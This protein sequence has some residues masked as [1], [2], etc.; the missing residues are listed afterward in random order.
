[1]LCR[2]WEKQGRIYN[3][4]ICLG[5]VWLEERKL[6][7]MLRNTTEDIYSC[8]YMKYTKD[9]DLHLARSSFVNICTYV[10]REY[11]QLPLQRGTVAGGQKQ[12]GDL[13]VTVQAVVPFQ[14]YLCMSITYLNENN[15]IQIFNSLALLGRINYQRP[16]KRPLLWS[17]QAKQQ[18]RQ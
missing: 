8:K 18:Q 2:V 15:V 5:T 13:L 14:F 12:E 10:K 3:K 7:N 4:R 9:L 1:M 6:E 11:V 16:N 17:G